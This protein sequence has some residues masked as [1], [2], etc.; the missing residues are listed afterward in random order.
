MY[1]DNKSYSILLI[2]DN[3]A[4]QFLAIE[5]LNQWMKNPSIVCA[6][7][8]KEAK[9]NLQFTFKKYDVIL[10]DL[11]L[12]DLKGENLITEML[13]LSSQTPII[14]LSGLSS[15]KFSLKSLKMGIADY[16]FKDNLTS[17]TLYKSIIHTISRFEQILNIK[18]RSERFV[19][20]FQEN[21]LPAF[22]WDCNAE[23]IIDC[24]ESALN[25]YGYTL[26]EF[27]QLSICDIHPISE[28]SLIDNIDSKLSPDNS[29]FK[30][31]KHKKKDG[32]VIYINIA[33]YLPNFIEGDISLIILNDITEKVKREMSNEHKAD[34]LDS[35]INYSP[36]PKILYDVNTLQIVEVNNSAVA[37]YGYSYNEFIGASIDI[38]FNFTE[39]TIFQANHYHF[40]NWQN[41]IQLGSF[42]HYRKDQSTL[43]V[44]ISGGLTTYNNQNC[45]IIECVEI[46]ELEEERANLT[47]LNQK[48]NCLQKSSKYEMIWELNLNS[49]RAYIKTIAEVLPHLLIE[50]VIILKETI[51]KAIRN[52]KHEI[53]LYHKL[54]RNNGEIINVITSCVVLKSKN[55]IQGIFCVINEN[56]GLQD[57]HVGQLFHK[58][59][60][61][62]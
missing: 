46:T 62:V 31:W 33:K 58:K 52:N 51:K 53:T 57:S 19:K 43:T 24:N 55:H 48:Y 1:K 12:P 36:Q 22:L 59:L 16:L 54:I 37:V 9:A 56:R 35:I 32:R 38:L 5:Y 18:Y 27:H 50:E 21:H 20:L 17:I 61:V 26:A 60:Q 3:P 6:Q 45:I 4:D 11:S 49:R 25:S 2:E 28:A 44:E 8:Y 47:F 29:Q 10:L 30:V 34:K 13:K 15:F 7:N 42:I 23:V 41:L 39:Y 14:I 40:E